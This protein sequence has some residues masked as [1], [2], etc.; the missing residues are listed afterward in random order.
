[1]LAA[2]AEMGLEGIVCKHLDSP[3][4]PGKRSP[5]WIKTPH[6]LRSEFVIGGWLPGIGSSRHTVGALLL[7]A[8]SDD[9]GLQFCGAVGTGLT[10]RQR[11]TLTKELAVL[12]RQTSPFAADA[13]P[14][15]IASFAR[16]VTPKLVGD[17]EYRE[18]RDTLRHPSWKGLRPDL[19]DMGNVVLPGT[20][21][22]GVGSAG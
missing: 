9:G 13:V 12:S 19:S 3:Y 18:F 5:D 15:D 20:A 22:W 4:T 7:G 8:C 6:R 10:T 17:V 16:W 14:A 21:A 11:L 2:S 1:V